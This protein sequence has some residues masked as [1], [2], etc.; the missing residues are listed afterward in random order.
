MLMSSRTAIT[1]FKNLVFSFA[2]FASPETTAILPRTAK[3]ASRGQSRRR[4]MLPDDTVQKR[5]FVFPA[6]DSKRR[7]TWRPAP[8]F[9]AVRPDAGNGVGRP[10]AVEAQA[11]LVGIGKSK[12]LLVAG[13][14]GFGVVVAQVHVVKKHPAQRGTV[15][16]HGVIDR[17]RVLAVDHRG[18][19][20]GRQARIG[21]VKW[22]GRQAR[23]GLISGQVDD[24][25][26]PKI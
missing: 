7:T 25:S 24:G 21:I 9:P 4:A 8:G 17:R 13:S 18:R 19:Q 5:L 15:A 14:T 6:A 26:W 16:R 2:D 22:R 11:E 12:G 1:T 20:V 10:F 23:R 3:P